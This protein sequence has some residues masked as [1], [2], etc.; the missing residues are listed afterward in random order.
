MKRAWVFR[1]CP[2]SSFPKARFRLPQSACGDSMRADRVTDLAFFVQDDW[3]VSRKLS[4]NAGIRWE[5]L[6]FA[7]DKFG[8]NGSF[9]TR[10][11]QAPP[12]NGGT[13]AGFVQSSAALRSL[14][15]IPK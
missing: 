8:R 9:D 1:A 3:K 11:Y 12:A 10:L 4:I 7:V 15:G 6:G 5:Y 2:G 13:S 14:A